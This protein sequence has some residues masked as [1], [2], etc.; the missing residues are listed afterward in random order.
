MLRAASVVAASVLAVAC[1][2]PSTPSMPSRESLGAAIRD[3]GFQCDE[4]IE[5]QKTDGNVWRVGCTEAATYMAFANDAGE[6]CVEPVPVGDLLGFVPVV[7]P[8]ARCNSSAP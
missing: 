5:S 6:I 4:V 7:S 2:G 8:S 3:V 1:A